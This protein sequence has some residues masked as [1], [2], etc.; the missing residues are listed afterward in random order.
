[1]AIDGDGVQR[2]LVCLNRVRVGLLL[3]V[4]MEKEELTVRKI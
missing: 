3:R 4:Y 2:Q 1:M